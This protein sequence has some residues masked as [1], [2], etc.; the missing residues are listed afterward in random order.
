MRKTT[1][2]SF[3]MCWIHVGDWLYARIFYSFI[4]VSNHIIVIIHH[5]TEKVKYKTLHAWTI[6]W[7]SIIYDS[8]G[9][10]ESNLREGLSQ[11]YW[12]PNN[13]ISPS[14]PILFLHEFW[15]VWQR[16]LS[17]HSHKC[18]YFECFQWYTDLR[19]KEHHFV[20]IDLKT[21][22]GKICFIEFIMKKK[23]KF[24]WNTEV[25]SV[26]FSEFANLSI[27]TKRK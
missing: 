23:I 11:N 14:G 15:Q 8:L 25:C 19:K 20:L 1:K 13:Q 22:I 2:I 18:P 7:K 27:F 10:S 17:H 4:E 3:R 9:M 5:H 12:R 24:S 26:F 21:F 16:N 6:T